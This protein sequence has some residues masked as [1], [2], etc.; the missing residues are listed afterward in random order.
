MLIVLIIA[1]TAGATYYFVNPKNNQQSSQVVT[2]DVANIEQKSNYS[3]ASAQPVQ[4]APVKVV[5]HKEIDS[6]VAI[7][8][9]LRATVKI[10]TDWGSGSGFFISDSFIVT[11]R[12]VIEAK[13]Q[14][15][16]EKRRNIENSKKLIQL[17]KQKIRNLT[18]EMQKMGPGPSREQLKIYIS[19]KKRQLAKFLPQ[20]AKR[21][22]ELLKQEQATGSSANIKIIMSD[23]TEYQGYLEQVSD[24]YDLALISTSN[25][26]HTKIPTP[27]SGSRLT[28]GDKLFTIGS[29]VGLQNT[30]TA[31][32]FSGYRQHTKNK[33]IYIQTD[34]AIN[35]GNSGGPLI[36]ERGY[37]QGIN[38]MIRINT[39]GI[40]FAIPI[41]EVFNDFGSSLY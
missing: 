4:V 23:G 15:F 3:K 5:Q 40:G 17:E 14:D 2:S 19:E 8:R 30:V 25:T 39:E 24:N 21:E 37:V 29:P 18:I 31:G 27:Q 13:K 9:A 35:P 7:A 22:A 34:A 32:I 20:L 33:K 41:E 11:N 26:E 16:S 36:D 28:E 38:T 10:Q 6:N 12:H 1:G